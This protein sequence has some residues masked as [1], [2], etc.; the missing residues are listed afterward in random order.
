[1]Y[2]TVQF[3]HSYWAYLALII[4]TITTINVL[5]SYFSGKEFGARD[6]RLAL[7]TLIV[8]HIQLLIGIVLYFVSP[9]G[10]KA[11]ASEGISAAMKDPNLR[12]YV[13]EHPLAMILTV[14]FITVG[15]SKHKKKLTSKPKFKL[16]AI[17]YTL[18][19][20]VMLSRIPWAN[21]F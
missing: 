20:I 17:F 5:V 13:V 7:F 4:L 21:W 2:T 15:Y 19:L 6:F 8:S 10:A 12:L 14:I 11:I 9:L 18:A 1:M 16:L 3:V